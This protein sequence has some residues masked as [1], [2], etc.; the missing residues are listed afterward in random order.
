MTAPGGIVYSRLD[1]D[2]D[3]L[4][5]ETGAANRERNERVLTAS[6]SIAIK[7]PRIGRM[8]YGLFREAGLVEVK[9]E[10]MAGADT[11]GRALPMLTASFARYAHDSGCI[12]DE[13]IAA[14][15]ASLNRAIEQGSFFFVLPQFVA[16]GIQEVMMGKSAAPDRANRRVGE[17]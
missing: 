4:V 2:W 5:L 6:K 8:L 7:E 1:S 3:L 11:V 14:W 10:I 12:A 13:E 16:R 15:L 17:L 9:V